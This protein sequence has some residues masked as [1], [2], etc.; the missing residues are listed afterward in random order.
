MSGIKNK[1]IDLDILHPDE[2]NVGKWDVD[3]AELSIDNPS[4]FN[5]GDTS[6]YLIGATFLID[7]KSVEDWGC[8]AGGFKRF[9]N[10]KYIGIDGSHTPFAEKIVDLRTYHSKVDGIFMRHVL[11]HNYKW[12]YII[13][14]ALLSYKK[15][16]C[17]V[18]FTKFSE[19]TREIAH[20]ISDGI[21]VP[22]ISFDK[23]DLHYVIDKYGSKFILFENIKTDT[24]Y[25]IEH[26]YLITKQS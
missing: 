1:H 12:E 8:G 23:N 21:D 26:V 11:E 13:K 5:Y 19:T 14:N 22:D 16:M 9:Y 24:Q 10:G 18:L 17:L 20:N 2:S 3:Y 7:C 15:K 25:G 6:T 4:E